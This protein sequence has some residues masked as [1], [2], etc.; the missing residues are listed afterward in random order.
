MFKKILIFNLLILSIFIISSCSKNN[1]NSSDDSN[2]DSETKSE[3][4]DTMNSFIDNL[5]D[6]TKSYVPSWNRES[7]KNRWNYIDGVFLK[8]IIDLYKKTNN[9]K[10]IDFVVKYVDY[11]IDSDGNFVCPDPN[12]ASQTPFIANELD[13]ICESRILFDLYEYNHA[14]KYQSAIQNT[15]I[16]LNGMNKTTS[17]NYWHKETYPNQI[18]L[19]GM[20]MYVPFL[21]RTGSTFF[22]TTYDDNLSIIRGQYEYIREKMYNS[23]KHLYYHGYD[24]SEEKIFWAQ[25]NGCSASFWLRSMGWYITSLA[26]LLEYVPSDNTN[27]QYFVDLY[28]EAIDGILQYKDSESNMFYQVIDKAGQRAFVPYNTYLKPLGN[29]DYSSDT[30]INNYLESSGSSLIAYSILKGCNL[31]I[32]ND[33]YKKIGN[34]IFEGVYNHSFKDNQLNDICITAGLGPDNRLY[35]DGSFEYY[36][37]EPVGSN[38]AKGV[39]PFIMAYVARS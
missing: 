32:L 20:Y 38:D 27:R 36:L 34:D 4:E 17:G 22:S 21:A 19:D 14:Q 6:N 11:Y 12:S 24:D 23:S 3:M 25:S 31:G 15:L 8:S 16:A 33:N 37:A 13:S 28:K 2:N 35:R 1:N 39:G 30:Y 29:K 5:M 18:W 7:F 10:Y 26:D 9:K